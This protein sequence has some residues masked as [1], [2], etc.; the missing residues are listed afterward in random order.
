MPPKKPKATR[1][2]SGH[3]L[4]GQSHPDLGTEVKVGKLPTQRSV[5]QYLFYRKNLPEHKFGPLGSVICC[6]HKSGSVRTTNTV[7]LAGS[8]SLGS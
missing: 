4:V 5:L 3:F 8:V 7:S 6:P 2:N 1:F